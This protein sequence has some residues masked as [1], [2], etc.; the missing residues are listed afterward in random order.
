MFTE[1]ISTSSD[2]VRSNT[3]NKGNTS[4]LSQNQNSAVSRF[5]NGYL[6]VANITTTNSRTRGNHEEMNPNNALQPPQLQ[7]SHVLQHVPHEVLITFLASMSRKDVSLHKK[8]LGVLL[9]YA[10]HSRLHLFGHPPLDTRQGKLSLVRVNSAQTTSTL[11]NTSNPLY[12]STTNNNSHN[13]TSFP[14]NVTNE[15]S[16][17][18]MIGKKLT[19][20]N[21]SVPQLT[22]CTPVPDDSNGHKNNIADK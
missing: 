17:K 10:M 8:S 4:F 22:I 3:D 2:S 20:R 15:G 21:P 11:L 13:K 9:Y 18:E 6:D 1:K 19:L 14:I 5:I 12:T 7:Q 16:G